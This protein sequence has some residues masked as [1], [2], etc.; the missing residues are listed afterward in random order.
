MKQQK[1]WVKR[2][3]K[4]SKEIINK[5]TMKLNKASSNP[6]KPKF[7]KIHIDN[8]KPVVMCFTDGACEG[9]GKMENK[10]GYAFAAIENDKVIYDYN[11]SAVNTTN[12]K[13]ELQAIIDCL[14]WVKSE[15]PDTQVLLHSD[16]QYCIHGICTW[17]YGWIRKNW[18]EVK[19]VEQWQELSQLVDSMPNVQYKWVKAHQEDDGFESRYNRHVDKLATYAATGIMEE[20]KSKRTTYPT[21]STE[22]EMCAAI[23]ANTMKILQERWRQKEADN[24]LKEVWQYMEQQ[25]YTLGGKGSHGLKGKIGEY[26]I[27][28]NIQ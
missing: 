9:N 12:N 14:Q 25:G 1:A 13:M 22:A 27:K 18:H 24:L 8:S 28:Y 19:N 11:N 2:Q 7:P 6:L 4:W 26:L 5:Q 16:S 15:I 21:R 10:G 23:S 20:D 17:R 3:G